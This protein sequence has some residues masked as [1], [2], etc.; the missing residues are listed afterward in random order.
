MMERVTRSDDT[1]VLITGESGTG[2]ELAARG[3]HHFSSR[4]DVHFYSVNV[5][6]V[7][8]GLF[9]SEF[10][11]HKKGAFTGA[12]ADKAGWFEIAE[13][14]TLFMDEICET[15]PEL[16]VK[17]LKVLEERKII[18]VGSHDEI[19]VNARVITATNQDIEN[20]VRKNKFRPDL[21]HR[22]N[23]FR[24]HIPPLRERKEDIPKLLENF[25][26]F[27]S[28]K[29][30]HNVDSIEEKAVERLM[31]YAFPGNVRE[32]KNMVERAVI[33]CDENRLSLKHFPSIMPASKKYPQSN[34]SQET[35][36]L[37]LA[38]KDMITRALKKT[39]GNKSKASKLLNISRQSLERRIIKFGLSDLS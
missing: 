24:I 33:L 30:N 17:L 22:L 29:I 2:K 9:E 15:L 19:P 18:R 35:F 1:T 8:A 37:A 14:S 31:E 13:N 36:D 4:K 34:I 38:E 12:S 20:M 7:P 28:S 26:R 16:Q 27:Y 11:G 3:I 39:C 10:F 32:L 5:S 23:T 21:Y 6:A 25:I